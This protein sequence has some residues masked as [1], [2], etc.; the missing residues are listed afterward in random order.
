M[1]VIGDVLS[2]LIAPFVYTAQAVA[3]AWHELFTVI[4]FAPH[5]SVASGLSL[6]ATSLTL[7][8]ALLLLQA[9]RRRMIT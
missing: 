6:I 4:G 5:G 1:S 8:A 2:L 9:S 3:N 7:L